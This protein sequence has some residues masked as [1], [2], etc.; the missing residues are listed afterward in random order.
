MNELI[1]IP[2]SYL[3]SAGVGPIAKALIGL[4]IL[5]IG[6]ILVNLSCRLVSRLLNRVDFLK[7]QGKDGAT[8]L[9]E[10]IVALTKAILVVFVLMSVLQYYGLTDVL[11][12]LKDMVN[13]FVNAIPNIIGASIIAYTGWI[14]A[15]I[16]ADLVKI[17]L[18]GVDDRIAARTGDKDLKI[19]NFCSA[20]IF[21]AIL[22]P[23]SVAALGVLS[24]PAITDPASAMIHKLMAAIPN[25]VGAGVIL[26]VVYVVT[27]F[28][29]YVLVGLLE[30]MSIDSIPE[31]LG[32]ENL[33]TKDF[34]PTKLVS[35]SV[36][37]FSMLAASVAAIDTLGI[38]IVTVIF[39]RIL[40]FSGGILVGAII[41]LV[42][43]FLSNVVYEK[44]SVNGSKSTANIAKFAILG[45]VFAM[46]LRA[47]GLADNIV[48]MAFGLTIGGAA[49]AVALA[50]GLGGRDAA[51]VIADSW[52]AKVSGG[53]K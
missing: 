4:L 49:I 13:K 26:L 40:E 35:W 15:K 25:I 50:F 48:N 2:T 36:M 21:G 28:V 11:A 17:A 23:I 7:R 5:V 27:K 39:S 14:L 53:K 6:L 32:V 33:F 38:D 42:G 30:G 45:L 37:F 29:L 10:P 31:K 22:L 3:E 20:F 12:P 16:V 47:M 19:S 24:I 43:N 52:A 51:K 18:S 8:N 46:G 1:E 44:I 41:L 34:T 9:V